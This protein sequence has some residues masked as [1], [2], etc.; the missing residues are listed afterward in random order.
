MVSHSGGVKAFLDY[1][2][3]DG[4]EVSPGPCFTAAVELENTFDDRYNILNINIIH[5]TK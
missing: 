2:E 1:F 3:W 5:P 4:P